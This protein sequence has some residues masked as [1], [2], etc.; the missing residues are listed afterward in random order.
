MTIRLRLCDQPTY[1]VMWLAILAFVGF[2]SRYVLEFSNIIREVPRAF[3]AFYVFLI[4]LVLASILK[5]TITSPGYTKL[6]EMNPSEH[7][8]LVEKDESYKFSQYCYKCSSIKPPKSHHCSTCRRCVLE[9]DHHC[10]WLNNC[11]GQQ[12]INHFIQVLMN[13]AILSIVSFCYILLIIFVFNKKA[14]LDKSS[15]YGRY[16]YPISHGLL[17]FTG[18]MS[19]NMVAM[20]LTY[21]HLLSCDT[22]TI[23]Q[24]KLEARVNVVNEDSSQS[25]DEDKIEEKDSHAKDASFE[26][27]K[28][29]AENS[30]LKSAYL[31][32]KIY[33][34][35]MVGLFGSRNFLLWPLPLS[36]R[37]VQ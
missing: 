8:M 34:D 26:N 25:L 15:Y 17:L 32:A 6:M 14:G 29:A 36:A 28:I 7:A 33:Y 2:P 19:V 11:I 3:Q 24:L 1:F 20:T 27:N 16:Q 9:M 22:S 12:N 30:Y 23:D 10:P 13:G 21:V 35:V 5:V 31:S 4:F 37:S 18:A